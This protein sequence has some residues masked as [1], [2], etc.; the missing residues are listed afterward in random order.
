[1]KIKAQVA[2][3]MNLDKCIGCHTCS[4]TCKSTWTNREGAE[5]IWFNNVETKP[6]VGYPK[7]WEDQETYKGGWVLNKKGK[8]ELKSG[9]KLSKIALG[10]IFFNPDMPE[11]KDYYE[12]WTYN[13]KHLTT[14]KESK[15]S[16]VAKAESV[17]SGK[18]L[19]I[20]WGPN[21]E[22]DL[23]G[24]HVTGPTDPNIQKIEEEIKFNF[25][26]TFMMYL[27]R[28]C[29][30][31]LNPSCVASCPSGAM[32]KRD[33][34]GIVLVDQD[35]CRGWRYCMT[36]CP[37]KKVYFNWKTN[38]AEKC[39]FC[40]PRIEA[41]LPTVCSETC[42]GRMRYLGVLLYDADKVQEA[43]STENEQDLYEKQL[44][45]FLDPYD[46]DVIQQAEKDGITQDWIEAAQNSPVY[47]LAIEYKLAFPLHPEYRTLPMVWYCP[48]L[49][50]I[51]NYF[52]GKDSI[53]N[54]DMIFP[55]IEEMRLPVQYL[56]NMLTAGDTRTVKLAL[57]RMAMMRSYM[58]AKSS[59]KEFDLSRLDRVGLSERQT[60][61]MYRLLAIAKHEDRF[62]VPTS[63][64]EG[65]M[66]TY[67]AQGSQGFGGEMFGSNCDGCGVQSISNGKSGQ[68]I[69]NENF[70][71]GIF[72]D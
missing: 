57:Q 70:Y 49:S 46:E 12:P 48:P 45:L 2:M 61:D 29:E 18:K 66:D 37:Y 32:Y 31:C 8:L 27:P 67:R 23:A 44:D 20:K 4:V 33:E 68:E 65:Y 17:I 50:P 26:Q 24:A 58:R 62:V 52:E 13:Y 7:R 59:N 19:D 39:T 1:M 53:R 16:P 9:S 5:Y 15:H 69:Y 47:K 56:A 38:K 43:A 55:A 42:T 36:G 40:F 54:P 25:D 71:G 14:A 11:M 41:G 30:H 72:R 21:W 3:V 51:M 34:D 28:L 10:K 6:G 60:K 64:K 22:D 63:H 35:A